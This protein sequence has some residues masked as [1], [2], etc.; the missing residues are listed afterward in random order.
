MA[1][2]DRLYPPN[3]A[4]T[5]P[6]FY[7]EL[8]G[9]TK[10]VVPFSMNQS[11]SAVS[12]K[13]FFL[14]LKR[15]TTDTLLSVQSTS[16]W[17][18][19]NFTVTFNL[20]EDTVSKMTTGDY[21]KVQIAYY[22]LTSSGQPYCGHY[23]T[24]AIV[25]YT[26]QPNIEIQSLLSG[27]VNS[28]SSQQFVGRYSNPDIS[29]KVYQYRFSIISS[30]TNDLGILVEEKLVDTGWL[31][32]DSTTDTELTAST[33]LYVLSELLV[34][35]VTYT[36]L[37]Q[38]ITN[39]GLQIDSPQYTMVAVENLGESLP[40]QIMGELD[41]DNARVRLTVKSLYTR[42]DPNAVIPASEKAKYYFN[43]NYQI[44]R[45]DSK[46]NFKTWTLVNTF[47]SRLPFEEWEYYD[48]IVESGVAYRYGIQRINLNNIRSA[49]KETLKDIIVY[50]EDSYFYD[51]ERQLRVNF[52]AN[53]SSI[54]TV[55]AESKK[56][57]LGSKYPYI[58]RNGYLSYKEFPITGVLS[59]LSDPDELF[60]SKEELIHPIVLANT[61]VNNRRV[62]EFTETT[63]QTDENVTAEKNFAMHVLSWLNNGSIKLFKS[64]QEGN[65]I[66]KCLN[67]S[68]TPLNNTNRMIHNFQCTVDE[69]QEYTTTALLKYNLLNLGNA[70]EEGHVWVS[71]H[72][73]IFIPT[74]RES[75]RNTY[76][77]IQIVRPKFAEYD[78]TLGHYITRIEI[79]EATPGDLFQYGSYRFAIPQTGNYT[80]VNQEPIVQQ[81]N[82]VYIVTG[83][84]INESGNEVDVVLPEKF[85]QID[86]GY[87]TIYYEIDSSVDFETVSQE[88]VRTYYGWSG[89]GMELTGNGEQSENILWEF[90]GPK[91]TITNEYMKVFHSYPIYPAVNVAAYA[92][93]D[94]NYYGKRFGG[95]LQLQEIGVEQLA[96]P[97]SHEYY[98]YD[99]SQNEFIPY[100]HYDLNIRVKD[101]DS[102]LIN[103]KSYSENDVPIPVINYLNKNEVYCT[104]GSNVWTIY[105]LQVQ[106]TT[107]AIESTNATIAS[108]K[109]EA[110]AAK[111]LYYKYLWNFEEI[112]NRPNDNVQV[113]VYSEDRFSAIM[114]TEWDNYNEHFKVADTTYTKEQIDIAYT[115]YYQK[116]KAFED[117]LQYYLDHESGVGG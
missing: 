69:V 33:D 32:H 12:V 88:S 80:I 102:R 73:T 56:T 27:R 93:A 91:K 48:Y 89:Y 95:Y 16:L 43:G 8:D 14:R 54:K 62:T 53:V 114:S 17:D 64:S 105:Y 60:I 115:S 1:Y 98:I 50:F 21:Y 36:I 2:V 40:C 13:G 109:A 85:G 29:E 38:I 39:N 25:K 90:A 4:G 112:A 65:Y 11:V 15:T 49:R 78:Y 20:S 58:L 55:T 52:N 19:E 100:S 30:Y 51:G 83:T 3:I 86:T 116:E 34:T 7:T 66:I 110:E 76:D 70:D 87:V 75:Y 84:T 6:S 113:Y 42:D 94:V 82:K 28:V 41:Y 24:V 96:Q 111:K 71:S 67:V 31:I 5:L 79:T 9:T 57:T 22:N 92:N 72:E 103:I 35:G 104:I 101:A 97:D 63:D 46:S 26:E 77:D 74:V 99:S 108:L 117:L 10:L 23:S 47:Q 81:L 107:Y 61:K 68:L 59:Y 44:V 37:Y 18:A 45:T 106:E